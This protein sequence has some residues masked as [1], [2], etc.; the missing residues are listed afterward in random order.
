[1]KRNIRGF[2]LV[3]IMITVAIIGLLAAIA[4]PSFQKARH[5]SFKNAF[6]NDMRIAGDAF[7]TY[8]IE[9]SGQW[10]ANQSPGRMPPEMTQ[11]LSR[12]P[13]SNSPA[14]GGQWDWDY[15]T[16]AAFKAG[17]SVRG[18]IWPDSEM[19]EIDDAIDDGIITSGNFRKFNTDYT[20]IIE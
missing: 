1:M 9:H 13:W 4:I 20:Y 7:S 17:I 10:P 6:I 19:A 14:I 11:Y 2:T 16:A 12:F 3:E 15:N 18:V 5:E 8:N